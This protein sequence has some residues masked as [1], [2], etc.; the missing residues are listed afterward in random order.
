MGQL[1]QD[2][3]DLMIILGHSNGTVTLEHSRL[4]SYIRSQ[5]MGQLYQYTIDRPIYTRILCRQD[6]YVRH[7][8]QE[9]YIQ[10]QQMK[11]L[12]SKTIEKRKLLQ[13]VDR[14][15]LLQHCYIRTQQTVK[16]KG[17]LTG[18]NDGYIKGQCKEIKK[19]R[20]GVGYYEDR[21]KSN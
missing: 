6:S 16:E 20:V 21:G 1:Y 5:Q 18:Y 12:Q 15:K 7:S 14:R 17:L 2:A 4:D 13:T 3:V 9:N 11:Q 8:R 10:I 19:T